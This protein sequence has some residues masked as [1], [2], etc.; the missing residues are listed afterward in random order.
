ME[1]LPNKQTMFK[2]TFT[3]YTYSVNGGHCFS[4]V[5]KSL[6]IKYTCS[7][8]KCA[9]LVII[10]KYYKSTIIGDLFID[11][12]S[13]NKWITIRKQVPL[14]NAILQKLQKAYDNST[15]NLIDFPSD[16]FLDAASCS[17]EISTSVG[18][19]QIHTGSSHINFEKLPKIFREFE[20]LTEPYVDEI[21]R[22]IDK[23]NGFDV[24]NE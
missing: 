10:V 23:Q 11:G 18:S 9:Q 1:N 3:G 14:T 13:Q 8:D 2:T 5:P 12:D 4:S 21:Y 20:Q 24:E 17:Y 6:K 15:F 22:I 19:V 7:E 16:H